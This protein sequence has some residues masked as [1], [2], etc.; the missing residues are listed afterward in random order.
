MNEFTEQLGKCI[1]N[2]SDREDN[3][4]CHE[5]IQAPNIAEINRTLAMFLCVSFYLALYFLVWASKA[6]PLKMS[7]T[8]TL[9]FQLFFHL[10]SVKFV[11]R[12]ICFYYL[13]PICVCV[14]ILP[15]EAFVRTSCKIETN[16][17]VRISISTAHVKCLLM[18]CLYL[19]RIFVQCFHYEEQIYFEHFFF[20]LRFI[21]L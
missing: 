11:S 19:F 1:V 5:N 7:A 18:S 14:F 12:G 13:C 8:K 6:P 3:R 21:C 10:L 16:T 9:K 15:F 2:E 20:L 4:C 17:K